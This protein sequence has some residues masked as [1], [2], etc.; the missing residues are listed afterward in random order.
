MERP[1]TLWLEDEPLSEW[2]PVGDRW[3]N[4]RDGRKRILFGA[5]LF[6]YDPATSPM[7]RVLAE[8]STS[9]TIMRRRMTLRE[10]LRWWQHRLAVWIDPYS[11]DP[12]DYDDG[13]HYGL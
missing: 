11:Y 8:R 13:D 9:V 1:E 2:E 6:A 7:L 3:T 5:H 4:V 12:D 10:R